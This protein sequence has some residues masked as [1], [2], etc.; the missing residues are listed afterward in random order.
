M[1]YWGRRTNGAV[2]KT[3]SLRRPGVLLLI[4]SLFLRA[5]SLGWAQIGPHSAPAVAED[6]S[7]P[8]F[9]GKDDFLEVYVVLESLPK[10]N[11][12]KCEMLFVNTGE[13][14]QAI[15]GRASLEFAFPDGHSYAYSLAELQLLPA[16][17]RIIAATITEQP[18]TDSKNLLKMG[19]VAVSTLIEL[20]SEGNMESDPMMLDEL[21]SVQFLYNNKVMKLRSLYQ[22]IQER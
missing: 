20:C 22:Q 15:E 21:I 19:I 3:G 4:I 9:M 17:K 8:L 14:K 16:E 18:T 1:K 10:S 11:W 5:N 13:G 6:V 12:E 7:G 2:L